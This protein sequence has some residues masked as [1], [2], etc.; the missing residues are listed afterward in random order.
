MHDYNDEEEKTKIDIMIQQIDRPDSR[1]TFYISAETKLPPTIN[2][3]VP[4]A[5]LFVTAQEIGSF[6][7]SGLACKHIASYLA[8]MSIF[9]RSPSYEAYTQCMMHRK[10]NNKSHETPE[11]GL[12]LFPRT[13]EDLRNSDGFV[14]KLKYCDDFLIN[15]ASIMYLNPIN[16]F[17]IRFIQVVDLQC[18]KHTYRNIEHS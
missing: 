2:D 5:N 10:I 9:V 1:F 8:D 4:F 16:Q 3:P 18:F 17:K 6:K 7:F 11:F 12:K 15:H 14:L 13:C